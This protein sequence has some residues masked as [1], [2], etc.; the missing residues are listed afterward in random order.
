MKAKQGEKIKMNDFPP[1]FEDEKLRMWDGKRLDLKESDIES[2]ATM[3]LKDN[4]SAYE[5]RMYPMRNVKNFEAV[6]MSMM[7][8]IDKKEIPDAAKEETFKKLEEYAEKNTIGYL[9]GFDLKIISKMDKETKA[10]TVVMRGR[11]FSMK[12]KYEN[13]TEVDYKK[14]IDDLEREPG[15]R[16]IYDVKKVSVCDRNYLEEFIRKGCVG[17]E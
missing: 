3:I 10:I 9:D 4:E 17:L 15:F 11:T 1:T 12:P 16:I 5:I 13:V 8:A 7:M 14:L 2:D 6:M